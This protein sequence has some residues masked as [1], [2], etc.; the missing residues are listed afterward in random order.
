MRRVCQ[1]LKN[2]IKNY[3]STTFNVYIGTYDPWWG[4]VFFSDDND[5]V[6]DYYSATYVY[7]KYVYTFPNDVH[8][9]FL[10]NYTW[11]GICCFEDSYVLG[12]LLNN[13]SGKY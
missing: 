7:F 10:D 3:P 11:S 6:V 1:I 2:A 13:L 12:K 9:Y 5:G 8:T 4:Y